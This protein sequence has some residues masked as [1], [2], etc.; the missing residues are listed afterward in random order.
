MRQ[1]ESA[2]QAEVCGRGELQLGILVEEMRREGFEFSVSPPRVITKVDAYTGDT[3]E[4]Y[5]EAVADVEEEH[6]GLVIEKMAGRKGTL[7]DYRADAGSDSGRVRLT[8]RVPSRGLLALNSELQVQTSGSALLSSTFDGYDKHCGLIERGGSAGQRG[9]LVAATE[10][11][12]TEYS[13]NMTQERGT[14]FVAPG[15]QVYT[16][17]IVGE[18]AKVGD[19]DVNVTKAKAATNVR[20]V[21]KD[22]A[23]MLAPV[24]V[25]TVEDMITYVQDDEMVEVTPHSLRLRKREL[26]TGKR[27]RAMRDLKNAR[28]SE[29]DARRV[30]QT[31]KSGK[32]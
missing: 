17:M 32:K 30:A 22:E 8:F 10:G 25:L 18:C 23:A 20:S 11:K 15:D 1:L 6:A 3:M 31:G 4:P 16:G 5:E 29:A 14:M 9:K 24:R 13:L 7:L 28:L 12:A 2:E 21:N 26:D 19:L 27:Q